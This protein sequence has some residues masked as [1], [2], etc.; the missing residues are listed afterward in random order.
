MSPADKGEVL[1]LQQSLA[2]LLHGATDSSSSSS[3]SSS[4]A[5]AAAA[6]GE[7]DA[8]SEANEAESG[9]EEEKDE[10]KNKNNSKGTFKSWHELTEKQKH[11]ILI[12]AV[13]KYS[14]RAHKKTK[15]VKELDE[16][17]IVCQRENPFYVE[18]VKAFRDRRYIFKK[19]L[20]EAQN[21]LQQ[22][23]QQNGPFQAKKEAAVRPHQQQQQQQQQNQ[24]QQQQ[25]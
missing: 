2:T 20:K 15:I 12:K 3:S 4:A 16:E 6:A 5:A 24:Q 13:K 1:A 9:E 21:K 25:Q 19:R 7:T 22:L 8:E 11:E 10:K 23:Q 14:Q 18:T 17:S